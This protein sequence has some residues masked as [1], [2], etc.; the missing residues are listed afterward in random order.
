[1][2]FK[3]FVRARVGDSLNKSAYSGARYTQYGMVVKEITNSF[4]QFFTWKYPI[5]SLLRILSICIS[6]LNRITLGRSVKFS[7]AYT[8]EDRIL[9]S[10]FK[11]PLDY[12]GYYVDVGCNHPIFLSNTYSFYR[13]GWRGLCIDVNPKLIKKFAFLRPRDTAITALV[14]DITVAKEVYLIENDVLTTVDAENLALAKANNL[15]H[16]AINV[17]PKTLT[18]ILDES[19]APKRIDILSIDA[20]EH[21]FNVLNSLDFERYQPRL[22]ITE[23]ESF[24]IENPRKNKIYN[25]LLGKGYA[26]EGYILKNLYFSKIRA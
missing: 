15:T 3:D 9:E 2:G 12:N 25:L 4:R 23:D 1:M 10:V 13:R 19:K 26:L 17:V 8:G 18:T 24:D 6:A 20:E 5:S 22:I 21:D 16:E 14:S 11:T 7:Y